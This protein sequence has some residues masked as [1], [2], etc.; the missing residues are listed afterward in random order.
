MQQGKPIVTTCE[1]GIPDIVKNFES[2]YV[3]NQPDSCSIANAIGYLLKNSILREDFG[4]TG[5]NRYDEMFTLLK[6]ES[7]INA[8]FSGLTN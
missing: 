5:R 1:C 7:K 3:V 2:G 6:F 4:L 8:I